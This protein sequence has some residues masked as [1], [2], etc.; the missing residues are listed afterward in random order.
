MSAIIPFDFE[1]NAVRVVM[2]D[3]A[4]WFVAADVCR[5]LEIAKHR[6]AIAKLDEDERGEVNPLDLDAG[7]TGRSSAGH[8]GARRLATVSE[9]G[10]YALI[11]RSNKPSARRFRRWVTGE[12]LPALRRGGGYA[13]PGAAEDIPAPDE[14]EARRRWYAALPETHRAV[15]E[16]RAAALAAFEARVAAGARV[17]AAL[18]EVAAET[19]IGLRTLWRLRDRVFLVPRRDWPVALA[20]RWSGRQAPRAACHPAAL[21]RLRALAAAGL[22]PSQAIAAVQTEAAAEGWA[23]VS[24]ARTLH[25]V[26]ARGAAPALRGPGVA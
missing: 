5:V 13:L 1:T 15:A 20:P 26:L 21:A 23:P 8:G 14:I 3:G 18:A 9:S 2:K 19:G 24:S 17:S 4:P 22:R 16:A 12:V 6:D 10:L 11:L 7:E 25:R